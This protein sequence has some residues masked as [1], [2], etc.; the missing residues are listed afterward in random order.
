MLTL[1]LLGAASLEDAT[2]PLSG[3]ATQRHRLSLLALL[4]ASHPVGTSRDKLLGYLWPER[5]PES[6]RNLLNQAIYV[7]R[8]T[9]GDDAIL[10]VGEN[11]RLVPAGLAVDLIEFKA[12]TAAD[13]LE[14]AVELY[15]GPFLDGFFL[16]DAREF[17]GWVDAER[18]RLRNAYRGAL[19]GLARTADRAGDLRKAVEWWRRRAAEDPLSGRVTLELMTAL[20]RAGERGEALRQARVHGLLLQRELGAQPDPAVA[21]LAERMR[22]APALEPVDSLDEA[23]ERPA[24]SA[25]E[26][27]APPERER[28][29]RGGGASP[30]AAPS[31]VSPTRASPLAGRRRGRLRTAAVL[32]LGGLVAAVA[33][34]VYARWAGPPSG[35]SAAVS[36]PADPLGAS[37]DASLPAVAVLAFEDLSPEGDQTWFADGI[38]EEILT[39]LTEVEGMRVAA[40]QS[41]FAFR[42]RQVDVRRIGDTLGV[43]AVL[44]GSVRKGGDSVWVTAQLVDAGTGFHLWSATY[45][46][47]PTP[48]NLRSIQRDVAREV[49]G[50]LELRFRPGLQSE[51]A[52]SGQ[53]AYDRYLQGRFHLRRWQT[54]MAESRAELERSIELF[55]EAVEDDPEWA[56]SWAALGEALHWLASNGPDVR[57]HYAESKTALERAIELDPDRAGPH[58]SLAFVLH[59]WEFDFEA[60]EAEYRRSLALGGHSHWHAYALFLLA[61]R[62][63]DEAIA[64]FRRAEAN[65]PLSLVIKEQLGGAYLCAERYDEAIEQI[66]R[67]P[68]PPGQPWGLRI[69]AYALERAGR[70]EEALARL[71]EAPPNPAWDIVRAQLHARNGRP[72]EA[73]E[74]IGRLD[75]AT[76]AR[77]WAKRA[78]ATVFIASG[79]REAALG[80]LAEVGDEAP[81]LLLYD[82]SPEL[83]LL[84]RHPTYRAILRR[85]GLPIR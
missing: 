52:P 55:R 35:G 39:A 71:D 2:G 54:G 16:P 70:L 57:S 14:R 65:D 76:L 48:L 53:E 34:V 83:R 22:T 30:S 72:Q 45:A 41:S 24:A 60:A 42:G 37:G 56:P 21:A 6:G 3:P 79:E 58:A 15:R 74:L 26:A 50:A 68:A 49:A 43:E 62:R 47:V 28:A 10:S 40:R 38:A 59:N 23:S 82:C 19:E 29:A 13:D 9:L 61:A 4:A 7:L 85:A 44:E 36:D 75:A 81:E 1:R 25:P 63:Y 20:E 5:D 32:S 69:L 66:E 84:Q 17:E 33:A 67:L 77:P 78:R 73:R 51:R 27:E 31:E 80:L 46:K 11:L 64:A 12:V 8:R 18:A